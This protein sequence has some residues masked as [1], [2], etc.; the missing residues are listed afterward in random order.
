MLIFLVGS[1]HKLLE[2]EA[3]LLIKNFNCGMNYLFEILELS[4]Q[5]LNELFSQVLP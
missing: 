1:K 2:T 4:I 5:I 3:N